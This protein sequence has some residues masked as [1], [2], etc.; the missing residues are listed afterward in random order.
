MQ[1][2]YRHGPDALCAG[3]APTAA[4]RHGKG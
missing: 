3:V 1:S 2:A 4:K